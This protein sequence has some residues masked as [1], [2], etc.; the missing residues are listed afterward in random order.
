M[1]EHS[2]KCFV[3]GA[4]EAVGVCTRCGKAVCS[5]CTANITDKIYCKADIQTNTQVTKQ[6]RG[7][8]ITTASIIF[9]TF[10][11]LEVIS[12]LIIVAVLA[13][14]SASDLLFYYAESSLGILSIILGGLSV[15]IGIADIIA[16]R[17][18][19]NGERKG[20]ILGFVTLGIGIGLSVPFATGVPEFS[21]FAVIGI[22]L[23]ISAFTLIAKGWRRLR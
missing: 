16:G 21:A 7:T 12:G 20:G 3:H 10:G 5:N 6:Q 15:I 22:I 2:L 23:S 9:Y 14:A 13:S 18:L 8:A 1:F 4:E 17:L 19:W 11:T